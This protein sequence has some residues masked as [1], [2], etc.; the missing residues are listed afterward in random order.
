MID[1]KRLRLKRIIDEKTNTC[2]ILPMDHG[3]FTGPTKGLEDMGTVVRQA[4]DGGIDA[5]LVVKGNAR[6]VS[7]MLSRQTGLI[8]QISCATSLSPTG[9]SRVSLAQSI[10]N[11]VKLGADGVSY[12]LTLG[13]EYEKEQ[14]EILGKVSD[15]CYE[16]G[17]PLLVM[18]EYYSPEVEKLGPI[19]LK[20]ACRLAAEFGADIIKTTYPGDKESFKEIVKFTPAPIVISGGP[21]AENDEGF[22]RMVA[23]AIEAGAIGTSVGRNI[24]QHKNPKAITKAIAQI[25]REKASVKAALTALK[26]EINS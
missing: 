7:R 6:I 21:R 16:W 3:T 4:V 2:M 26:E 13:H 23:D 17:I 1:G 10:E 9:F 12:F 22:L 5:V 19:Y 15:A 20:H 24:F 11:A 18:A 14:L 25:V 8:L